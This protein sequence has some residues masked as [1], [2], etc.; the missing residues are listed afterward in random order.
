MSLKEMR[1]ESGL[2]ANKVAEALG[3]S[4]V[5][6]Y[7]LESGKNKPDKLKISI[8]SKIYNK[9]ELEISNAIGDEHCDWRGKEVLPITL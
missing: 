1:I 3:V 5:Q 7:N 9:S 6:L 2:K 4:R 8:L